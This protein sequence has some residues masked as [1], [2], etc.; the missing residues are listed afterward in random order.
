MANWFIAIHA[1]G[2]AQGLFLAV[3]LLGKHAFHANRVLAA[4]MVAFSL[5]LGMAVYHQT[6]YYLTVPQLVGL[7]FPLA[8]LY[9]PLLYLYARTLAGGG[10]SIPN[11]FW[12]HLTPFAV[13]GLAI[14]PFFLLSGPEK[15]AYVSEPDSVA[16]GGLLATANNLKLAHAFA[17]MLITLGTIQ[18]H[19]RSLADRFSSIERINLTWLRN[20][21]ATVVGVMV[22]TL[23]LYGLTLGES[24][25][26]V[27]IGMDPDTWYD[28][29]TL[30]V[31]AALVYAIGFLGL[32]QPEVFHRNWPSEEESVPTRSYTK[33]GM[34]GEAAEHYK[35]E[36]LRVMD[37][38]KPYLSGN[39]SLKGLADHLNVSPHNLTEVINTRL[40]ATFHDFVNGY[41]VRE[42]KARLADP[43]NDH[44]SVLGVGLDSG[45]KSK[46]SFNA[47]FKKHVGMTPS[48]F[49]N[50]PH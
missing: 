21:M 50:R 48:Q 25:T 39:L 11:G 17:Y 43:E 2:A 38:D 23:G 41:R 7:D 12:W 4:L 6:G 32:R 26:P 19:R 1:L 22:L 9:G 24:G 31:L 35:A 14:I 16:F 30:V 44:L 33:S 28:E 13:M 42:A 15:L 8:F 29:M 10:E 34:D 37:S 18:R 46:S 3:V 47:V 5:D 27:G 20:L 45:F 36:L 49:R 40:D